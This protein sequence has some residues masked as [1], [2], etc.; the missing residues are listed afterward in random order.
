[1]CVDLR[2][3]LTGPPFLDRETTSSTLAAN[4][5]LLRWSLSPVIPCSVIGR[6]EAATAIRE[7]EV[8][9]TDLP[10]H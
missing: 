8:E 9:R 7:K 5:P 4:E 10:L 2:R 6:E 3:P 1:M